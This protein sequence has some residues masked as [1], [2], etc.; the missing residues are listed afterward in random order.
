[1]LVDIG[2]YK[3]Y[4]GPYNLCDCLKY[5]GVSETIR[6][7]ISEWIPSGPFKWIYSLRKRRIKIRIDD[8]DVWNMD[9]TLALI[10][11]PMLKKIKAN[12]HGSPRV[13]DEDVPDNI[14]STN[15]KPTEDDTDEF[16]HQRWAYVVD[17]MIFAFEQL[18]DDDFIF[19]E[20]SV[21]IQRVQNGFRLFGKY[22]MGLW[23]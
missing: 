8:Y 11:L 21:R 4:F 17:E 14:K 2:P 22:Y 5:I 18:L 12:K 3:K 16:W 6:I 23:T 10:I 19:L 20:N 15:A 7:K 13:D 1:M 9:H